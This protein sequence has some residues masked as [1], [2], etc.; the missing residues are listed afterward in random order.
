MRFIAIHKEDRNSEADLPPSAELV[1]A[2]GRLIERGLKDGV[3]LRGEGLHSSSKRARLTASNGILTILEGP[4]AGSNELIAG[5]TIIRVNS[6]DEAIEWASRLAAV[7][8]DAEIEVGEVKEPW[9]VGMCPKPEGITT[10]RFLLVQKADLNSE[11]GVPLTPEILA[12]LENLRA[13]MVKAGVFLGT[14]TLCPSSQGVR[15]GCFGDKRTVVDGPFTEAKE[16]IG[17]F[18]IIQVASKGG[19]LA[20]SHQFADVFREARVLDDIE[21]DIYELR[22]ERDFADHTRR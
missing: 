5:V 20:W 9:D 15:L 10:I 6:S 8:G 2:M 11:A 3:F 21:I 4:Y 16:L 13:E 14:E 18:A 12:G 22:E 1:A 17:G 7:L 19:A